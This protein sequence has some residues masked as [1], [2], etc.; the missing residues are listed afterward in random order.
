MKLINRLNRALDQGMAKP[1][2]DHIRNYMIGAFILAVGTAEMRESERQFFDLIP[3][4][5]AGT[6]AIGLT[7]ILICINLYDGIRKISRSKYHVSLTIV[8]V[9]LYLALSIR[10]IEMAWDFRDLSDTLLP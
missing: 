6:G 1:I 10:V 3:A 7:V 2:F 9:L 8:L 4:K 5:F